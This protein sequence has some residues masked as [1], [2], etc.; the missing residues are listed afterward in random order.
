MCTYLSSHLNKYVIK[1]TL[2][3]SLFDFII[4]YIKNALSMRIIVNRIKTTNATKYKK[5]T[6]EKTKLYT[7]EKTLNV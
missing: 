1:T 6:L 3:W 5:H 2:R 4:S 7:L